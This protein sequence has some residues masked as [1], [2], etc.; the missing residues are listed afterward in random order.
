[1][2]FKCH[3]YTVENSL[4]EAA[5]KFIQIAYNWKLNILNTIISVYFNK[6]FDGKSNTCYSVRLAYKKC[7][8]IFL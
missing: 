2:I 3:R 8:P 4:I 7:G 1:M 5:L 6:T